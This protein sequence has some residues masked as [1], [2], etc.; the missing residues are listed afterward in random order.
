M[1]ADWIDE[2]KRACQALDADWVVI[3]VD[4]DDWMSQLRGLDLF[5]WHVL[6]DDPT[7]MFEVRTKIP[8]VEQSGIACFPSAL[9]L[10]LFDDKV[11][12]TLFMRQQ[13]YPMPSTFVSFDEAEAGPSPPGLPIRW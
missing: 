2:F 5:V 12:E 11:R 13:G 3:E 9:M 6:M 4:R 8:L 7:C 10:W 1:S